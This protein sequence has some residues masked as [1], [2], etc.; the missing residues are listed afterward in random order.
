MGPLHSKA[1][2]TCFSSKRPK[3][4]L[5]V[6]RQT[7]MANILFPND[8]FSEF[9]VD[10][11]WFYCLGL[12]PRRTGIL[13]RE[14]KGGR[15]RKAGEGSQEKEHGGREVTGSPRTVSGTQEHFPSV[16]HAKV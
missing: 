10:V 16:P 12:E 13:R 6:G 4:N 11:T 8:H 2:T 1:N 5:S 15:E 14:W 3:R 7:E 9:A